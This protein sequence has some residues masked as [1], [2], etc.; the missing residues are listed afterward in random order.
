[1]VRTWL[2]E[3]TVPHRLVLATAVLFACNGDREPPPSQFGGG[4]GDD[5]G[6]AAPVIT[7]FRVA[8]KGTTTGDDC[9]GDT[10]PIVQFG[11]DV[12]DEDGALDFYEM[13]VWFDD[14]LDGTVDTSGAAYTHVQGDVNEEG[15][16]CSTPLATVGL[17]IK[18]CDEQVPF[19]VELEWVATVTDGDGN[20]SAPSEVVV[21]AVQ[22]P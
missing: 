2:G 17:S 20:E 15:E 14:T 18:M 22:E 4:A 11:A 5:C 7:E 10:R 6:D 9:S 8:D 1:M 19:G 16:P 21:F 3:S 13:S 12:D